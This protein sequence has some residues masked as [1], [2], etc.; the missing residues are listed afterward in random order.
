VGPT[1][2][3]PLKQCAR[4]ER[5]VVLTTVAELLHNFLTITDTTDTT[6]TL[7]ISAR[8]PV[9]MKKPARRT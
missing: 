8:R 2:K 1:N 5:V 3:D 7:S 4:E 6:D 9:Y